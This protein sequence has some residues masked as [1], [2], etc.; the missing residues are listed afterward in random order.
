MFLHWYKFLIVFAFLSCFCRTEA[1]A[2][3]ENDTYPGFLTQEV[4]EP[5]VEYY[6]DPESPEFVRGSDPALIRTILRLETHGEPWQISKAGA[7]GCGQFL[8]STARRI[9]PFI[10]KEDLLFDVGSDVKLIA[11][12]TVTLTSEIRKYFGRYAKP[13]KRIAPGSLREKALVLAAYNAGIRSVV[14]HRGVPPIRE[15]KNYVRRGL[16][17]Y[18]Y[19]REKEAR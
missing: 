14:M 9:D 17:Y 3:A 11:I 8:I 5:Y 2:Q 12:H 4:Y 15:T 18:K 7:L 16:E 19:Y 6:T 13:H 1:Y 10:T